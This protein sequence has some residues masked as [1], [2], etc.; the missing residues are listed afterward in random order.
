MTSSHWHTWRMTNACSSS[1]Y[2]REK[3]GNQSRTSGWYAQLANEMQ[4]GQAR[5][6]TATCSQTK[7]SF[8]YLCQFFSNPFLKWY[9]FIAIKLAQT[10][11][12]QVHER[13]YCDM[14]SHRVIF[15]NTA[16]ENLIDHNPVFWMELFGL[17]H[18]LGILCSLTTTS[19][20][21]VDQFSS[22]CFPLRTPN[23]EEAGLRYR[24]FEPH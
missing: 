18:W 5:F 6:T 13:Y 14:K 1:L 2:K 17:V 11:P 21:E 15:A 10:R 19:I 3:T 7:L 4:Q 24:M 9:G 22:D 16:L 8:Y 23:I 20:V 12:F